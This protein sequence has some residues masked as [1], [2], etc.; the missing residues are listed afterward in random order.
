[1]TGR[2]EQVGAFTGLVREASDRLSD[3]ATDALLFAIGALPWLPIIAIM[4]WLVSRL[5]R[6]LLQRRTIR[7]AISRGTESA[8]AG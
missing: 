7:V 8:P 5:W 4:I 2:T 3:N 1:M 6:W